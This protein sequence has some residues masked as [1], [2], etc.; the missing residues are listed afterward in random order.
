MGMKVEVSHELWAKVNRAI[1]GENV[2]V[3]ITTLIDGMSALLK[4]TGAAST[5]DEA[6]AMLAASIVSPADR[7]VG[8]LMP[9]LEVELERLRADLISGPH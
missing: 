4:D 2:G 6:R 3:V 7:E 9:E 1:L 8:D 5:D